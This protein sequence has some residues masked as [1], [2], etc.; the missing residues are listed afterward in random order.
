[1]CGGRGGP[2]LSALLGARRAD[3]Q[4]PARR[5]LGR[6]HRAAPAT[7]SRRASLPAQ[8]LSPGIRERTPASRCQETREGEKAYITA[9]PARDVRVFRVNV[10]F[11]KRGSSTYISYTHPQVSTRRSGGRVRTPRGAETPASL[12]T[13]AS[14]VTGPPPRSPETRPHICTRPVHPG[15]PTPESARPHVELR[16]DPDITNQSPSE[17][18]C[19]V[20]GLLQQTPG[21][22]RRCFYAFS[23]KPSTGAVAELPS[24]ADSPFLENAPYLPAGPARRPARRGRPKPRPRLAE[25]S[26]RGHRLSPSTDRDGRPA[27]SR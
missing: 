24:A 13:V 20:P 5:V 25:G 27:A 9:F 8:G 1:M 22:V 18:C 14:T 3:R 2:T 6:H 7:S 12:S 23:Q 11:G 4:A 21:K 19:S 16:R 17:E 15:G 10:R 26:A